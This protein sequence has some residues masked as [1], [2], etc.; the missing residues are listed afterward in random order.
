MEQGL[1]NP[2]F[3]HRHCQFRP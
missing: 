3:I 2:E 1:L